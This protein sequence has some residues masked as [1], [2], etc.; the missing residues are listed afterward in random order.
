MGGVWGR[1]SCWVV[2]VVWACLLQV[3]G[4]ELWA[5]LLQVCGIGARGSGDING[6]G[7]GERCKDGEGHGKW[8]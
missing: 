3:C 4:R 7:D 8:S 6:G 1:A 2:G 5:C